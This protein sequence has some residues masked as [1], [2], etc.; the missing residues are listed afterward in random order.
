[1]WDLTSPNTLKPCPL[2]W[3]LAVLPTE[4]S[5]KRPYMAISPSL[6]TG[7]NGEKEIANSSGRSNSILNQRNFVLDGIGSPKAV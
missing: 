1:M 2:Q 7:S 5:G 3:K 4:P 6:R